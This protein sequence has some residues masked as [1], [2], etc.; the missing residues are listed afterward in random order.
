MGV[1]KNRH[2]ECEKVH[3][4]KMKAKNT[5]AEIEDMGK[6]AVAEIKSMGKSADSQLSSNSPE[7]NITDKVISNITSS[8]T[9]GKEWDNYKNSTRGKYETTPDKMPV[10]KEK[11]IAKLYTLLEMED[12]DIINKINSLGGHIE[13]DIDEFISWNTQP[14]RFLI[15]SLRQLS[16][17][18]HID[19]C[20]RLFPI[21]DEYIEICGDPY[22]TQIYWGYVVEIYWKNKN[23][24]ESWDNA[25]IY[26]NSMIEKSK[27]TS[28]FIKN[29]AG[30]SLPEH[31]GYKR[32]IRILEREKDFEQIVKLC[33]KAKSEG[34]KGEWD[35][36]I[37][38][39]KQKL[40][41][42]K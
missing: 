25:K 41:K 26:C 11:L 17:L 31:I 10:S 1:F 38:K 14:Y 36:F 9:S 27:S 28:E 34:W 7:D 21:I 12:I 39:A 16:K 15:T 35:V 18:G 3:N 42:L 2:P 22:I 13:F 4:I 40:T 5:I 29:V 24:T 19:L 8:F 6:K 37:A 33:E 20:K 32:M 23:D 30:Y